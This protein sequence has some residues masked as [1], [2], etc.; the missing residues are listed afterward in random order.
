L[1]RLVADI[2]Q[3]QVHQPRL[4]LPIAAPRRFLDRAAQFLA[5]HRTDVLLLVGDRL[6]QFG[7]L[8][9]V[10]VEVGAQGEDERQCAFAPAL[11][12]RRDDRDQQVVDKRFALELV[13]AEGEQFL[14]LVND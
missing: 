3:D 6:P 7:V 9:E 13:A 11:C 2:A 4:E 5:R 12:V 8:G 10:R 1:A 14:E